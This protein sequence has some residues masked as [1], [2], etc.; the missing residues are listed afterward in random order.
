MEKDGV[1]CHMPVRRAE[2]PTCALVSLAFVVLREISLNQSMQG[3]ITYHQG[4]F[5]P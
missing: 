5:I 2:R 3:E 1:N 4:I